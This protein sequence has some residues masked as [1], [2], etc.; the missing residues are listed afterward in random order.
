MEINQASGDQSMLGAT[1]YDITMGNDIAKNAHCDIIMLLGTSIVMSQWVIA[2]LCVHIIASQCIMTLLWTSFYVLLCL[3]MLFLWIVWN[4]NKNKFVFD[5][6]GLENT[7][8]FC[9]AIS[10][11]L[12]TCEISLHKHNLCVLPRLIKHSVVLLSNLFLHHYVSD[13]VCSISVCDVW[14]CTNISFLNI[15]AYILYWIKI[16]NKNHLVF[17]FKYLNDIEELYSVLTYNTC[18]LLV[19]S[20]YCLTKTEMVNV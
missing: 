6:S 12:S 5:Q 20:K 17:F 16:F 9:R 7:F 4:K 3:F 14:H 15:Y 8:F 19:F 11:V 10:L 18:D 13:I 1:H 2:L